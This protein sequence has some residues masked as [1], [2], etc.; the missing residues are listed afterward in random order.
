M[1]AQE[2]KQD[3]GAMTP[4]QE[5]VFEKKAEQHFK[6]HRELPAGRNFRCWNRTETEEDRQKFNENFD[7]I[8]WD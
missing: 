6:G 1:P 2:Q 7:Q 8:R 5:I 4:A 3:W